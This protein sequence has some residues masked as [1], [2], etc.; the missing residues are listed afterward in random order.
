MGQAQT[1]ISLAEVLH[2]QG[3]DDAAHNA[4]ER[5]LELLENLHDP[6]TVTQVRDRLHDLT[7]DATGLITRQRAER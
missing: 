7:S 1:L 6:K 5:A 2:S 3:R 4:L